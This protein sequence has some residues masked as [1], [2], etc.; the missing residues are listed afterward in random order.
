MRGQIIQFYQLLRL[1]LIF[2]ISIS[3]L[4]QA[5]CLPDFILT[6]NGLYPR[7]L[8]RAQE[9]KAYD[10]KIHF[11]W[12]TDTSLGANKIVFDSLQLLEI[13]NLHSSISWVTDT[14]TNSWAGGES[15]CIR[16]QGTPPVG[17][18]NNDSLE[19]KVRAF[20]KVFGSLTYSDFRNKVAFGIDKDSSQQTRAERIQTIGIDPI[21]VYWSSENLGLVVQINSELNQ[22]VNFDIVDIQGKMISRQAQFLQTGINVN[23]ANTTE[24]P[25]GIY[26][27][28]IGTTKGQITQRFFR[29]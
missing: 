17:A 21:R 11:K 27:L 3:R 26:L 24:L 19:I 5:Q 10:Q 20:F 29:P 2:F 6:Y 1:S 12:P 9:N 18:A 4:A 7:E 16:F 14:S 28:R 8:P 23:Q 15:G 13:K 22:K 25:P